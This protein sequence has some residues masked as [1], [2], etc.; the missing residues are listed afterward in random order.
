MK[1]TVHVEIIAGFKYSGI[2]ISW[3]SLLIEQQSV[4]WFVVTLII[5]SLYNPVPVPSIRGNPYTCHSGSDA[6]HLE[7]SIHPRVL[8]RI[9]WLW[10]QMANFAFASTQK[11]VHTRYLTGQEY[12]VLQTEL[13]VSIVPMDSSSSWCIGRGVPEF[14]ARVDTAGRGLGFGVLAF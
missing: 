14:D 6:A 8:S 13:K 2:G 7:I 5:W 9:F 4:T 12:N 10:V 3:V 1:Y 11:W